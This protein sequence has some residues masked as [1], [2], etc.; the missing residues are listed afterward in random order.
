VVVDASWSPGPVLGGGWSWDYLDE[1]YA[2]PVGPATFNEGFALVEVVPGAA[3]QPARA[4][5]LPSGAPLVLVAD[6]RT[7]P[8]ESA[9]AARLVRSR[10]LL[11]DTV[12][13]TG[14]IAA[15]RRPQ[16]L[17]VAVADPARFFA[18]ALRQVLDEA[19]IRV[20]GAMR[21]AA[22][23]ADTLFTWRSRPLEEVL[24]LLQ[25][26]SQNQIGEL[27]LRT[28]GTLRGV[29]TADSGRAV[30]EETLRGWGISDGSYVYVDGSGLSR[31]NYVSPEMLAQV[32]TVMARHQHAPVFV[33]ALPIAGVDGTLETRMRGT[34]AAGNARGKTG[35]IANVRNVSGYVT[36]R[37]GER[38]VFVLLANHF[39]VPSSVPTRVQDRVIE[40]LAD[41]SRGGR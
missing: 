37:G 28:L 16:Q 38:L 27:L 2:A 22:A 18:A 34:A 13:V 6:V 7:I 23:G 41:F 19:G 40:R 9:S 25:K 24:P 35:T 8:A 36:T 33:E 12:R 30:V 5:L 3:G 14:T 20:T 17:D 26:P 29:A 39:T 32:L 10:E 15:G 31:Y 1:D 4:A 11:S 21:D